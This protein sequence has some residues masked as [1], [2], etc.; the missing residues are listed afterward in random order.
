VSH[1]AIARP[2]ASQPIAV[3]AHGGDHAPDAVI[4][5]AAAAV[6]DGI[7]VILVGDEGALRPRLPS[8]VHL[9][10]RHASEQVGD[11]ESASHAARRKRDSSMRRA[12]ELVRDGAAA[13]AV[14]CGNTGAMLATAVITL[15]LLEGV[16]RPAIATAVPRKDGGR[17][18]LL[19]SGANVDCRPE[20]LACFASLG[21]AYAEALGTARPRVG[22]LANGTERSKG[23]AQARAALELIEAGSVDCVGFVEPTGALEGQCDV[24][25]CDGFVGNVLVKGLEGAVD[26]GFTLFRQ[27]LLRYPSARLGAWLVQRAIRRVWRRVAWDEYGG[28][29]L[30]GARGVV[31]IGHGRSNPGAVRAAIGLAARAASGSLVPTVERRLAER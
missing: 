31:V 3:D 18:V 22:V 8:R 9:P 26:V 1:D 30:L 12:A 25:V 7:P 20:L 13:A 28:G 29:L 5:G 17:L 14:S 27:E 15:G 19:D 23:N 16:D 4:A 21:S 11:D 24:L 6:R 10:I 2:S